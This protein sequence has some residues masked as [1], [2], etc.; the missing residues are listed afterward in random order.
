MLDLHQLASMSFAR[1]ARVIRGIRVL[2]FVDDSVL[3]PMVVA[4]VDGERR[5]I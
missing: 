4:R 1:R 3:L 2:S 5:E